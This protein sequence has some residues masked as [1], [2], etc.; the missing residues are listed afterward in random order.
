MSKML[1]LTPA[2]AGAA[3]VETV[4]IVAESVAFAGPGST[5]MTAFA[6]PGSMT[7]TVFA[8]P[9]STTMTA[10]AGPGSMTMTDDDDVSF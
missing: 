9:G 10:F 6:G 1:L 5:T 4:G 2:V 7:M 3:A 8:G